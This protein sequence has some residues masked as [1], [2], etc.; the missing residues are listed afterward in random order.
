VPVR[1]A[2]KAKVLTNAAFTILYI[3]RKDIISVTIATFGMSCYLVDNKNKKF[4]R[5]SII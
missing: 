3:H 1:K 5:M 2:R 4:S